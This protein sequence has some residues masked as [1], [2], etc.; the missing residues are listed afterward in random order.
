MVKD[1]PN[2]LNLDA[3]DF[4]FNACAWEDLRKFLVISLGWFLPSYFEKLLSDP[5]RSGVFHCHPNRWTAFVA[6]RYLRYL[7]TR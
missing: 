7:N 5:E 2:F 4:P 1:V 6:A 3:P